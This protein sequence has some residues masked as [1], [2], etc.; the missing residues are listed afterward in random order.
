MTNAELRAVCG[1]NLVHGSEA[2]PASWA[3]SRFVANVIKEE[4][5]VAAMFEELVERASELLPGFG[6][7]LAF[8]GRAIP[9][10]SAMTSAR[11]R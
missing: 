10:Y 9:S 7:E 6:R 1:F 2:V 5:L 11:S 4:A 8:D 3:M